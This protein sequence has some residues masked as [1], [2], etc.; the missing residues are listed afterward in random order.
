MDAIDMMYIYIY[1]PY[2][3]I[4]LVAGWENLIRISLAPHL[5]APSWPLD[6]KKFI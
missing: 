5:L 2:L 6:N 1:T 4:F 3:S